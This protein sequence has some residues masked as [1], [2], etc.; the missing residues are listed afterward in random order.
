MATS[1]DL[2]THRVAVVVFTEVKA[3]DDSDA[4]AIAEHAVR[5]TLRA[6]STVDVRET[7]KATLTFMSRTGA[8]EYLVD[9]HAVEEIGLTLRQ[10]YLRMAP[11]GFVYQPRGE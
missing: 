10:G 5:D 4:S 7:G 3:I 8:R 11:T 6:A 1:E 9:V 2:P